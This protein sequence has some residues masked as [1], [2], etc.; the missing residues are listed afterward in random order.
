MSLTTV[1][2]ADLADSF[3]PDGQQ[4]IYARTHGGPFQ[5]YVMNADG[6]GQQPLT[7]GMDA[8]WANWG[9]HP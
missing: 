7:H 4:I 6:T 1:G 9:T 3:S 8:H 2:V 5:L